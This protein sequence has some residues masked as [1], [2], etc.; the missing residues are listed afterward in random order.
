MARALRIDIRT[1]GIWQL[2]STVLTAGRDVLVVDPGYF[3]RELSELGELARSRGEVA[4]VAFTHGH[5]DHV[6]GWHTFPGAAVWTSQALHDAIVEDTAL[7]QRNLADARDF[8]GRWY[9]PRPAG[10]GWPPASRL[11]AL[12]P[13]APL[14]LGALSLQPLE[15]P[16]HSPDGLG[17]LVAEHG[18]LLVGDYLSPCEIPFVDSLPEYR[19]TLARLITLTESLATIVPGH[20]PVLSGA[21]ARAIAV[22]DLTYLDRLHERAEAGDARGALA[23]PLP[24]AADVPGMREHHVDNCRKAGLPV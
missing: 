14:S 9:V 19:R 11:R 2:S 5:W 7:A 22:A 15:L 6:L 17:L 3:P 24:R 10:Y 21:E 23:L 1:S 4:A 8:D 16:G 20:G 13:E 12:R 18:L